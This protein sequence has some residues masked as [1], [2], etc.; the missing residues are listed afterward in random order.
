MA[1]VCQAGR[2]GRRRPARP[3]KGSRSP[4]CACRPSPAPAPSPCPCTEAAA[5]GLSWRPDDRRRRSSNSG[6]PRS[7]PP[8]VSTKAWSPRRPL[9]FSLGARAPSR[10]SRRRLGHQR[11]RQGAPCPLSLTGLDRGRR[12][13]FL[14]M[15]PWVPRNL[16]DSIVC[17]RSFA[18]K[19]LDLLDVCDQIHPRLFYRSNPEFYQFHEHCSLCLGFL[20]S[21]SLK[22]IVNREQV[23]FILFCSYLLCFSS[24]LIRSSCVRFI[25]M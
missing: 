10:S 12:K 24:V 2:P 1:M 3:Y 4:C 19:P 14:H 20:F 16:L 17:L 11:H 13:E 15:T 22:S 25:I 21:Y 8:Q 9:P 6:R 7:S 23:L 5:A 18:A